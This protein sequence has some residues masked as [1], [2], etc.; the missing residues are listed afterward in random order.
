[1]ESVMAIFKGA[2]QGKRENQY[3]TGEKY[4]Y[5]LGVETDVNAAE[6]WYKRAAKGGHAAAAYMYGYIMLTGLSGKVD[7]KR[8]NRYIKKAA[9]LGDRNAVLMLARNYYYGYGV[10]K[11]DRKAYRLWQKA[12]RRAA[13]RRNTISD[14]AM[15]RGF[16]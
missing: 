5:G 2:E 6:N 13:R 10:K 4:F 12:R 7:L 1:M 9:D 15:K 3:L 8:G 11:N 16:T 14:S